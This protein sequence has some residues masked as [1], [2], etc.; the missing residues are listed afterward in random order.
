MN[1]L[2]TVTD[3]P[4]TA[5]VITR[6]FVG[7]FE[8]VY[9][10]SVEI[11]QAEPPGALSVIS[12]NLKDSTEIANLRRWLKL[13][14]KTAKVVFIT[15]RNSRLET[16]QAH[17]LGATD[18]VH[19]LSEVGPLLTASQNDFNSLAASFPLSEDEATFGI[20][21]GVQALQSVFAA[22]MAGRPLDRAA[23]DSAGGA[24]V[25]QIHSD[26]LNSWI[27]TVRKHHSQTYQH[28]LL[29]TGLAVGFGRHIGLG[30]RDLKRLSFASV[31][32]DVG[33]ARV[34]IAIL[35]KPSAL[36]HDEMNI[37]KQHPSFGSEA[38]AS[39]PDLPHEMIDV[40]L[41]HHEYL[42]GSGYPHGLSGNEISDL[43]RIL[44]IADIFGALIEQRAYKPPMA[45]EAAYQ[46]LLDMG[47]KLDKDLMREFRHI[48]RLRLKAA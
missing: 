46:I 7:A 36:D 47:P 33:K 14:P 13:R 37:I 19:H 2:V 23:I 11:P 6:Q 20:D 41:H 5:S 24:I 25:E 45:S 27:D 16:A 8:T 18:V 1:R 44:T 26:G 15:E 39:T 22:A 17:A 34:P 42:D 9:I 43:V 35:E 12:V 29:V 3:S 28:S 4:E 38:L 40:V 32:H 48:A 30:H 31:L 21:A 10:P